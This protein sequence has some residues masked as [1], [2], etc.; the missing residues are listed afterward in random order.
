MRYHP[1]VCEN[2]HVFNAEQTD[3]CPKCGA[4]AAPQPTV[5]AEEMPLMG[6]PK[7]YPPQ[8]KQEATPPPLM[9]AM[10]PNDDFVSE[11]PIMRS[12]TKDSEPSFDPPP[13]MGVP[14]PPEP[15]A[16]RRKNLWFAIG[17]ALI[18]IGIAAI[19]IAICS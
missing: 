5:R 1:V 12:R 16:N 10:K 13:L 8:E 11:D 17:G 14:I 7:R 3:R 18:G 19:I 15:P 4:S 2:G 6:V 9:G